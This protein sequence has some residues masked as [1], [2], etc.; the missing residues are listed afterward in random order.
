MVRARGSTGLSSVSSSIASIV[1]SLKA[2]NADPAQDPAKALRRLRLDG[3][4]REPYVD[5]IHFGASDLRIVARKLDEE[6]EHLEQT[7]ARASEAAAA[8]TKVEEILTE[9]SDLVTANANG[10]GRGRR[11]SNQRKVDEL[12]GQL[13]QVVADASET[14]PGL[15]AGSTTLTAGDTSVEI[16][17]VSREALGKLVL[18][19][20]VLS[21]ADIV[22]RGGLDSSKR[23]TMAEGARKALKEA[24]QTVKSLREQLVTFTEKSVRPRISDV[25]NAV[26]G[27]FSDAAIG[28]SDAALKTAKELRDLT[29]ASSTAALAVGAEGWDRER[30]LDLLT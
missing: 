15:F 25:A 23:R 27:L 4:A 8:L 18:N 11:K 12:L 3:K 28:N 22:T 7:S 16:T 9:A 2:R 24:T 1:D 19:G 5:V 29:L 26:A 6:R 17:E 13:D 30:V 14:A 21:L 20:R 10:A